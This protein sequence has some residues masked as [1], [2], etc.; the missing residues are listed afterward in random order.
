M[1][2][3]PWQLCG[4]PGLIL[5]A[6]SDGGEYVFTATGIHEINEP[7]PQIPGNPVLEKTTRKE[8]PKTLVDIEKNPVKN[9]GITNTPAP[10]HHDQIETD[11][12]D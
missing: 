1:S 7:L 12:N 2:E 11:Y 3:G 5:E 10:L 9:F 6:T 8:Y 4:L